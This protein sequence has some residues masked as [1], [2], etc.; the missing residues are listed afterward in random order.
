VFLGPNRA[1]NATTI[2]LLLLALWLFHH[3]R[4]PGTSMTL[5]AATQ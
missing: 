4:L 1:G 5:T 2:R 3:L